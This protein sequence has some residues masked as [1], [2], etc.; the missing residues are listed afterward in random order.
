MSDFEFN[1]IT[2]EQDLVGSGSGSLSTPVA[3][4]EGGTGATGAQAAL[5]NLTQASSHT[6]GQVLTIQSD[7]DAEF[8]TNTVRFQEYASD[9]A[10]PAS[11]D[12]WIL[13]TETSGA[14]GTPLGMLLTI[15]QN[16]GASLS[17]ELS[18]RTAAG[19]TVR[20]ALA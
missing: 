7:G 1:P 20:A 12:A 4:A 2:R 10:S 11:G 3:I 15:T 17:Y 14:D 18:Y 6:T 9:P 8:S 13:R 19:A 16:V 5:N